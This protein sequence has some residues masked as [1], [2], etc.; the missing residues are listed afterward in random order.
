MHYSCQKMLCNYDFQTRTFIYLFDEC[1]QNWFRVASIIEDSLTTIKRQESRLNEAFLRSDNAGC[2]H[3]AFLLLSLPSLG[4]R[5]GIWIARHDFSEAQAGK[6][7][8]DR[9][10]AALTNHI[11]RQINEGND[12]K[13][14]NDMKAAIDLHGGIES[15]Y[16][17]VCTVDQKSQNMTKHSLSG[18]QSLNNFLY[19]ESGAIVA[20]RAYNVGPRKV[21]SVPLLARLGTPQGP[22]NLQVVQELS[23]PDMLTGVFRA[24][25]VAR[26][27]Q[28]ETP[29]MEP[30][31]A[32]EEESVIF[33]CPEEGCIKVYQSQSSLQ[34]HLDVG[35]HLLALERESM[36]DVIKKKWAETCKSIFGS[37]MEATHPSTSGSASV[38]LS[39]SEDTLP[40]AD[41][42]WTLKKT[43]KSVHFTTKVRQFLCE[44]FLQGEETGNKATAE[45]VAARMRSMRTT[46]GTK[47]FTKD[48]WLTFTQISRYFSRLAA[49]NRSGALYR[50]EE[51]RPTP[52]EPVTEGGESEDE[53]EDPYVAEAPIIRTR[54]QIRRELEL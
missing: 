20:W 2:Y 10:A 47:V 21:F 53:E 33:G 52:T 51:A 50:T 27:Q 12:V 11:R 29:P 36:Y 6:D 18:I 5:V 19:T 4:Q 13:T 40:T 54:L 39:Q 23:S 35:K 8:C 16:A 26:E 14:A 34:R 3:C 17:A 7:I 41:I 1:S 28:P 15:C 46:E 24:P 42:G 49:L 37:Y 32:E 43:K 31:A 48:E 9:R 30:T 22:T 25:S 45:D 38:S 44:V